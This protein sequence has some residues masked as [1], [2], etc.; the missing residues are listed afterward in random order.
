MSNKLFFIFLLFFFSSQLYS[1]ATF[2]KTYGGTGS[3]IGKSVHQTFDGGYIIVGNTNSFGAGGTDIWLIK[4]DSLGD[5]LWTKTFGGTGNDCA[6]QMEK[7]SD[8]GYIIIGSTESRGAGKS[9]IWLIKTDFS[10]DTL[11]TRTFG[12][13]GNETGMAVQQTADR[14]YII[15]GYIYQD[16]LG[17]QGDLL[18][19]KTDSLGDTLWTKLY[20]W[21]IGTSICQTPD[22]GYMIGGR[23]GC[24]LFFMKTDS[25]GDSI[26]TNIFQWGSA[27]TGVMGNC[28]KLTPDMGYIQ[29]GIY[30]D[31]MKNAFTEMFCVK[32]D[33]SGT[34]GWWK[35]FCTTTGPSG[36]T[37]T[38]AFYVDVNPDTTYIIT[39]IIDHHYSGKFDLALLKINSNGDSIWAKT[40]GGDSADAGYWVKR[41]F[42][43]GYIITGYTNSFGTGG[44]DIYL[45]KTDSV[46][47]V[48]VEESPQ[49]DFRIPQLS[50]T[51]NPFISFTT[52]KFSVNGRRGFP[53]P[54]SFEI[55]DISGKLVETTDNPTIGKNLKPGVYFV[56]INNSPP[57]KI[58]K[59]SS[60][61]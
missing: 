32:L 44:Q 59:L 45:V 55:F 38:E 4:T 6:E 40:Y 51:P 17:Y 34:I 5:T 3:D 25:A 28:V 56:R 57:L 14:G 10:G 39:G 50:A 16:S 43:G 53:T 58:I 24:D 8:N 27:Y 35:S 2:E 18:L 11:W 49:P 1:V 23:N 9:D 52:I 22:L 33:S 29:V 60:L 61:Q 42:D 47:Y 30:Y 41:T 7:T 46:G 48:A 54:I 13:T 19:I 36:S 20:D 26:W 21:G 37:G 15:T 31:L 12:D